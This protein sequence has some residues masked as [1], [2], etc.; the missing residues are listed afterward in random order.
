MQEIGIVSQGY[1]SSECIDRASDP[2]LVGVDGDG[3][4]TWTFVP[5]QSEWM[6]EVGGRGVGLCDVDPDDDNENGDDDDD[7][8]DDDNTGSSNGKK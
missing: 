8:D 3:I 7:D 4:G 6:C 1:R 5:Y 2:D